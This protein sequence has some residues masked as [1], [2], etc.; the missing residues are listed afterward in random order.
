MEKDRTIFRA[1]TLGCKEIDYSP[2]DFPTLEDALTDILCHIMPPQSVKY[3]VKKIVDMLNK[4]GYGYDVVIFNHSM[5][6]VGVADK[7]ME[8]MIKKKIEM[9][10]EAVKNYPPNM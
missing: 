7:G 4:L 5:V 1:T 3:S 2:V 10:R 8:N 9:A 6:F